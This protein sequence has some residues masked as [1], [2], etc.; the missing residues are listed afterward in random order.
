MN[1]LHESLCQ[2]STKLEKEGFGKIHKVTYFDGLIDLGS[3]KCNG[4]HKRGKTKW[5]QKKYN[6]VAIK[7]MKTSFV[8]SDE[9]FKKKLEASDHVNQKKNEATAGAENKIFGVIPYIP[10]EVLRV[11]RFTIADDIIV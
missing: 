1:G 4:E 11:E 2:I 6:E 8:N 10:P 9:V 7:F 3:I 5:K